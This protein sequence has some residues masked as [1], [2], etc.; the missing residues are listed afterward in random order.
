MAKAYCTGP[1]HLWTGTGGALGA[2]TPQY[3]GTFEQAP[4]IDIK[5]EWDQVMNDLSGSKLPLDRLFE[6]EE[7]MVS[8]VLTRFN[9]PT[10]RRLMARPR[11]VGT[12]G[13]NPSGD[14]GT[15]MGQ[16]GCSYNLWCLFPYR[17]KAFQGAAGDMPAGI[18]FLSAFLLSPEKI[19]GGTKAK[20]VQVVFQA[21]R[22]FS[23][24]KGLGDSSRGGGS[25]TLYDY[26]MAAVQDL[27]FD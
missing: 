4:D 8:G 7:G 6:G 25:F 26:S 11:F 3:L 13:F 5:G 21:Q 18:R 10:L 16:E 17:D 23:T 14:I 2:N 27:A 19:H 24:S 22:A 1:V 12:P 9:W 15:Y 20:K